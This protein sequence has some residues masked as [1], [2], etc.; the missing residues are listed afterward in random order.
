MKKHRVKRGKKR[1]IGERKR[2]ERR[3]IEKWGTYKEYGKIRKN[4]KFGKLF[5]F[6]MAR[7]SSFM[8]DFTSL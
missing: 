6:G 7:I 8:E 2:L 4:Q 1:A 3:K 5:K